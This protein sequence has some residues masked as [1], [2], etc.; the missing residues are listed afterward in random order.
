MTTSHYNRHLNPFENKELMRVHS[1]KWVSSAD[2]V[3]L[4]WKV[5]LVHRSFIAFECNE[6]DRKL[7][8]VG[9]TIACQVV[10]YVCVI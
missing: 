10:V 4:Q 6:L 9:V 8:P 3:L 7:A 2:Q 1:C 5:N